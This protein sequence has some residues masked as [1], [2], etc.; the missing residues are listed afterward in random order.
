MLCF[1]TN[2]WCA[3][4]GT[5]RFKLRFMYP[6]NSEYVTAYVRTI[7]LN[8]F[9]AKCK[10]RFACLP[11]LVAR[12][13][14]NYVAK[15]NL[16]LNFSSFLVPTQQI[17]LVQVTS[18]TDETFGQASRVIGGGGAGPI[19][20]VSPSSYQYLLSAYIKQNVDSDGGDMSPQDDDGLNN[21][22]DHSHRR[23]SRSSGNH[24]DNAA[25]NAVNGGAEMG[26]FHS[27]PSWSSASATWLHQQHH[28]QHHHK[29]RSQQQQQHYSVH[30]N[31]PA[32]KS[33]S[34]GT[35]HSNAVAT[36]TGQNDHLIHE[37][38]TGSKAI[39]GSMSDQPSPINTVNG[40]S[41]LK[42]FIPGAASSSSKLEHHH[43][44]RAKRDAST[45]KLKLNTI[46]QTTN[47]SYHPAGPLTPTTTTTESHNPIR[48]VHTIHQAEGTSLTLH[49]DS[50]G[51]EL[52]NCLFA[53]FVDNKQRENSKV[54]CFKFILRF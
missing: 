54:F 41:P 21:R 53:C 2:H 46:A 24:N 39:I 22:R 14:R 25:G 13:Q 9:K 15:V 7:G 47:V 37:L 34:N 52:F 29:H 5:L 42:A 51:G 45:S 19:D 20:T 1:A 26:S 49:C 44:H 17:R 16:V 36:A 48:R 27:F 3:W 4:P 50:I 38:A 6:R 30:S 33:A 28:H 31:V 32:T 11:C 43:Y 23:P 10:T 18:W 12:R 8:D 40:G 35:H